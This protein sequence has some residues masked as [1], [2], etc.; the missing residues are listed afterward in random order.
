MRLGIQLVIASVC[1]IVLSGFAVGIASSPQAGSLAVI[2]PVPA[3]TGSSPKVHI[4]EVQ[5]GQWCGPCGNAD[6]ALSRIQDEWGDNLILIAYHCCATS[7][8]YYDP[9]WDPAVLGPRSNFYTMP[10]LPE[11]IIDGGGTWMGNDNPLFLIGSGTNSQS[12]DQY[13]IAMEDSTDSSSNIA[14]SLQPDLRP[15]SAVV[16]VTVTA[17]DAVPQNNLYLR[18]LLFEDGRYFRQ[19]NGPFV[20]RNIAR[21][22][23]EQLLGGTGTLTLGQ[24]VTTQV[25]FPVT[26][27]D[28]QPN[29]LGVAA[30]V[31]SNTKR[32][33]MVTGYAQTYY[34]SDILN[35]ARADFVPRNVMVYPDAGN[36][37]VYSENLEILLGRLNETY[38]TWNTHELGPL[39][40][41]GTNDARALPTAQQLAD[42]AHVLWWN[43]ASATSPVLTQAE[44]DLIGPYLD[45]TA[46]DLLLT[47]SGIG[48]DGWNNYRP[49]FYQY[50]HATYNSDDTGVFTVQGVAA[51]PIGSSFA[52][53]TLNVMSSPDQIAAYGPGSA[54]PFQYTTGGQPAGVNA[55]HDGNSRMVYLGFQYF[56]NTGDVNRMAV[57]KAILD[58]L[59]GAAPPT[60]SVTSPGACQVLA[61]G[62]VYTIRWKASDVRISATGIDLFYSTDSGTSW[63]PIAA[64]E[65]NDGI[66]RW[67]VPMTT[68]SDARIKVA[69]HDSTFQTTEATNPADFTISP[70]TTGITCKL[71]FT[72]ADV[73]WHLLSFPLIPTSPNAASI[74]GSLGGSYAIARTYVY[75]PTGADEWK[76][77]DPTKGGGD[78][79]TLD[80]KMGFWVQITGPGTL[81]VTGDVPTSAQSITIHRGWNLVGFPTFHAGY[82]VA[83]LKAATGATRVE[84][85]DATNAPYYLQALPDTYTMAMGEGYWVYSP[86]TTTTWT[87]PL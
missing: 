3:S 24:T 44:R 48:F 19:N 40:D 20:H 38:D 70:S 77:Y 64:G 39:G 25:T 5:T 32:S 12:Y 80:Q 59:D 71:S 63:I 13:R 29:K 23:N 84:G 31:Q 87:V 26:N 74:L 47:G 45:N 16:T 51:N 53:T 8:G 50:L 57:L 72:S 37:A 61:P 28:I 34:A 2:P 62:S 83:D 58:W 81:S 54:V 15:G 18:T 21:A 82:T 86:T 76:A 30:F 10:Y 4:L 22:L 49:W 11:A 9:W 36:A 33:F 75:D 56:E 60:V 55:V 41:S 7:G 78:L 27:P 73:G 52:T 14:I 43:S 46:G 42:K 66:Y 35:T 65:P 85:L 17:T 68:T 6:P 67:T 69:A 79:A 1:A